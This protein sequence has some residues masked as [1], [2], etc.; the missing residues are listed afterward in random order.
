VHLAR[1]LD[2]IPRADPSA[3]YR[4]DHV[5]DP[6]DVSRRV[7]AQRAAFVSTL[8]D[9]KYRRLRTTWP[10]RPELDVVVQAADGACAAF[11][12]AWLDDENAVGELEPVGTDPAHARRGLARAACLEALHRLRGV[13]ARTAV[14]YA[15]GDAE[16]PAPL[17]LY[18]SLGFDPCGRQLRFV[19]PRLDG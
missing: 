7:A 10:Y 12:L 14:V 6:D 8:T 9:E 4:L 2:D 11:C 1:R 18:R 13:G 3:P 15:R 19:L 17:R 5:R 16:Y